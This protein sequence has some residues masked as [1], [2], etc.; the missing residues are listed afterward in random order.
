MPFL[1]VCFPYVLFPLLICLPM[2]SVCV[3][4]T[5]CLTS[6]TLRRFSV[7]CLSRAAPPMEVTG[8]VSSPTPVGHAAAALA[9]TF[10]GQLS[11]TV[12]Y[13]SPLRRG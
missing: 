11:V 13:D 7:C 12:L 3:R 9:L 2:G 4:N 10:S 8:A 6:V 1:M 5:L